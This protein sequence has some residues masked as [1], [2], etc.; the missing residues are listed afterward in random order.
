M[1]TKQVLERVGVDEA[2]LPESLTALKARIEGF[3]RG[4]T[5]DAPLPGVVVLSNV[6]GV[7]GHTYT[8]AI[9]AEPNSMML[10]GVVKRGGPLAEDEAHIKYVSLTRATLRLVFLKDVFFSQGFGALEAL[11][12]N[13]TAPDAHPSD[14]SASA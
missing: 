9:L 10:E 6:H 1:L 8:T 5:T 3:F 13:C 12:S 14:A 11:L 4:H 7:K 2:W